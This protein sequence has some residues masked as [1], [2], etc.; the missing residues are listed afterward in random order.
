MS[1]DRLSLEVTR[2]PVTALCKLG[3]AHFR[4]S[5]DWRAQGGV[6]RQCGAQPTG[7]VA[8]SAR[9]LLEQNYNMISRLFVHGICRGTAGRRMIKDPGRSQTSTISHS[10]P[11]ARV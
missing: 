6:A 3:V 5:G 2:L 11:S 1:A 9:S 7:Y 4:N 8:P 10:P